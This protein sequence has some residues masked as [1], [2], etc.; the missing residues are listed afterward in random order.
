MTAT[1]TDL[2]QGWVPAPNQRGTIDVLWNC[3]VTLFL[4]S[5][6]VLS[7]NLSGKHGTRPY[8]STKLSW[9]AFAILFPEILATFA[10]NQWLSAR[11]SV[12]EFKK[13]GFLSWSLTH[14]FFADMGGFMLDPPDYPPFPINAYQIHYLVEHEFMEFPRINRETLWD[15]NKADGFVRI[16]T[17]SQI[18]WFALQCTRRAA[19][20]SRIS[21]L[22]LDVVAIVLCTFPT[23]YFWLHKPLDV[24]T[25]ITLYLNDGILAR[26]ILVFANESAKEPFRYTPLDFVRAA[27]EPY[28]I[29]DP[30]M[31]AL[32]FLFG[33]GAAPK[34]GPI[35]TFKNTSLMNPGK[36][37]AFNVGIS[38]IITLTFIGIHFLA[39]DFEYPTEIERK[40]SRAACM[41]LLGCAISF[42]NLWLLMTWQLSNLCRLSGIAQVQTATQLCRKMHWAFQY[43]LT[44]S[45]VGLY[46]IARLY[47]LGEAL[48]G[49]RAL[50]ASI[51]Q[52]LQQPSFLSHI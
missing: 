5:W 18:L 26:D 46:G 17:F 15:K 36:V 16:I 20:F 51:F 14:A 52:S 7:L 6:S 2:I 4:C 21:T 39:W 11:Q 43:G 1:G 38:T 32:E 37:R 41:A 30:I 40:L 28:E 48:A 49:L 47:I 10:Q 45:H 31:W 25:P 44:L 33:L 35:S 13:L 34:H 27:P 3:V 12:S 50:P 23:L 19:Q 9:V 42:G 29:L 22:E 8:I 24:T